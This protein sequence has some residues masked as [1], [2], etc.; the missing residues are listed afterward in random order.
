MLGK[1]EAEKAE[2][3]TLGEQVGKVFRETPQLHD[4]RWLFIPVTSDTDVDD[5]E[6]LLLA[7]KRPLRQHMP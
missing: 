3:L 7:K 6:Q 5:V 4:G 2:A 1:A